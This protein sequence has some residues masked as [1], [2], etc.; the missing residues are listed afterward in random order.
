[1]SATASSIAKRAFSMFAGLPVP[2]SLSNA[3]LIEAT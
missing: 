3:S 2:R 1:M